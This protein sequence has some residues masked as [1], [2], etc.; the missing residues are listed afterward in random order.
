MG[1]SIVNIMIILTTF[2]QNPPILFFLL[3][4]CASLLRVDLTLP[5]AIAKFLAF[6][7]LLCIGF[8]G[9]VEL[10][11][12]GLQYDTLLPLV[13]AIVAAL[14]VPVYTFFTARKLFGV[15]D[16][17]AIAATYGSV[18]AVTFI[19]ATNFLHAMHIP[20]GGHMVAGLALMES[21][22]IMIGLFL[23]QRYS[24]SEKSED[25]SLLRETILNGSVFLIMGSLVIGFISGPAG[26]VPLKP[27]VVDIFKGMLTIFLFDMGMLAT[28]KIG[29]VHQKK[30]TVALFA[31]AITLVSAV[32]GIALAYSLGFSFGN[33]FLFTILC[34]SASYIA[35]PAA[36]R[37]A[38]PEANPSIYIPMALGVTFPFNIL[39]GFPLY[40]YI[41]SIFWR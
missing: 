10:H 35:V 32:F 25:F 27:F 7:L 22:A 14:V 16:A 30:I 13:A 8:Q 19:T 3:G 5:S 20:F 12:A 11:S 15:D 4:V 9:G 31:L 23:C 26:L 38:L 24:S 34:A 33:A 40:F 6:Y 1:S 29:N 36:M 21:P 2:F 41:L 37:L 17:A 28:T 39:I 18:S